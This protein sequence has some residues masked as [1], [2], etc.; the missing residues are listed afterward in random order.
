MVQAYMI[1]IH[2]HIVAFICHRICLPF[3]SASANECKHYDHTC[4]QG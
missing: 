2:L 4:V 1:Y 3:L